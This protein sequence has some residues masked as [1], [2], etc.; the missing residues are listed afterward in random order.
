MRA[1]TKGYSFIGNLVIITQERWAFSHLEVIIHIVLLIIGLILLHVC[2]SD[3][4][5]RIGYWLN[6]I[7]TK[8]DAIEEQHVLG[9][10]MAGT[11]GFTA[12]SIA[13]RRRAIVSPKCCRLISIEIS[14]RK[15]CRVRAD[16]R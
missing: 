15:G 11:A 1:L 7:S 5:D 9:P 3:A 6:N 12:F 2:L 14:S 4:H 10:A 8:D 13:A 16:Q